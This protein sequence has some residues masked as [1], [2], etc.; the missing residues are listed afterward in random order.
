MVAAMAEVAAAVITVVAITA[1]VIVA[2]V[3]G[4]ISA[5]GIMAAATSMPDHTVR[6]P[7]RGHSH[8]IG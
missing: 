7:R 3:T 1:A 8:R 2:E 5:A 6:F 4:T